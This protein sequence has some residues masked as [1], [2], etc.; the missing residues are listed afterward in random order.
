MRSSFGYFHLINRSVSTDNEL[1]FIRH[2]N[3]NNGISVR[4]LTKGR[5]F[6]NRYRK[7][8][9]DAAPASRRGKKFHRN[10]THYRYSKRTTD[11]C[12]DN[13]ALRGFF[14]RQQLFVR[15]LPIV[16]GPPKW[17]GTAR[18]FFKIGLKLNTY[19]DSCR[20]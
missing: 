16:P 15:V 4:V 6:R 18:F 19:Y 11:W 7:G 17:S 3:N 20:M 10:G 8:W 9:L 5:T 12:W 2:G 13:K 1:I 14:R